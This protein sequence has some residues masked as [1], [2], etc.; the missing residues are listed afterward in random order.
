[1]ISKEKVED[2]LVKRIRLESLSLA[3]LL[4][5]SILLLISIIDYSPA[6]NVNAALIFYLQ[7]T[8]FLII[9]HYKKRNFSL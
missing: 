3:F 4:S 8:L 2:E 1:M 6:S 7:L 9:Y 5:V